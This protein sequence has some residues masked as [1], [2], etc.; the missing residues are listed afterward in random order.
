MARQLVIEDLTPEAL[1][2]FQ[3]QF[4]AIEHLEDNCA[5]VTVSDARMEESTRYLS[6]HNL[7]WRLN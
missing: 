1:C 4:C 2:H 6:E 7:Q 5:V 3:R